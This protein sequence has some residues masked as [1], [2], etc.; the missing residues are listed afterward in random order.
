LVEAG[1]DED[2]KTY[3]VD[4]QASALGKFLAYLP[5]LLLAGIIALG[6]YYYW[7]AQQGANNLQT[8]TED[9]TLTT[10][11]KAR[12]TVDENP[13]QYVAVAGNIAKDAA[14]HYL[15]GRAYFL[16][17]NY[18]SAKRELARAR[19]MLAEEVASSNRRVIENDIPMMLAVIESDEA[20]AAFERELSGDEATSSEPESNKA[21]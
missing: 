14:D 12:R 8:Q 20:R 16:Q 3:R 4:E 19:G 13:A 18:E 5:W 2:T 11:E 6:A 21:N 15:L 9:I 1:V 10:F 7:S 17:G